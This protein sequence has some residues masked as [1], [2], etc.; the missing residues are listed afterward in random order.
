VVVRQRLLVQHEV[1]TAFVV[2]T[3]D[4]RMRVVTRRPLDPLAV[5]DE[6][7]D[8]LREGATRF[9][10]R[11][12]HLAAD[13]SR[14]MPAMAALREAD[15]PV[16]VADDVRARRGGMRTE[17]RG[18]K[19]AT[20]SID[21]EALVDG[22]GARLVAGPKSGLFLGRGSPGLRLLAVVVSS[23]RPLAVQINDRGGG[24]DAEETGVV[25]ATSVMN[26]VPVGFEDSIV[27]PK[28]SWTDGMHVE[29]PHGEGSG[30][31][32]RVRV[33][34][35]AEV[36][37]TLL[38]GMPRSEETATKPDAFSVALKVDITL[39]HEDPSVH[40]WKHAFLRVLLEGARRDERARQREREGAMADATAAAASELEDDGRS[41]GVEDEENDEAAEEEEDGDR[42]TELVRSQ[43]AAN[44]AKALTRALVSAHVEDARRTMIQSLRRRRVFLLEERNLCSGE[45]RT[46]ALSFDTLLHACHAPRLLRA[47][48]EFL[49]NLGVRHSARRG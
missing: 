45:I 30:A 44:D 12:A 14:D 47:A 35:D 19:R 38:G 29:E 7:W 5:G 48:I 32:M 11:L 8:V 17:W 3:V 18:G 6:G 20:R 46:T 39:L 40:V 16:E 9:G 27:S 15:T 10:L 25:Q 43:I 31:A 1:R 21:V 41:L 13:E 23:K 2:E 26:E 22:D 49:E 4:D 36:W 24:G 28:Q 37:G 33:E 42:V 34:E